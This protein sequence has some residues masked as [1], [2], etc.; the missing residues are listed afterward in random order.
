MEITDA[1]PVENEPEAGIQ[2]PSKVFVKRVTVCVNYYDALMALCR[3]L[4]SIFLIECCCEQ[5][6]RRLPIINNRFME[7]VA[8]SY[9]L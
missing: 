4:S 8:D 5:A 3:F 7:R 9:L 6:L 1:V 2:A